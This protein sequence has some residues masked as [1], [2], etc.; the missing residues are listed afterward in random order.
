MGLVFGGAT[1][2]VDQL[3][4]AAANENLAAFTVIQFV[5]GT[6]L[7]INRRLFAKAPGGVKQLN[8]NNGAG[9]LQ[10]QVARATTGAVATS[11][12]GALVA[13]TPQFIAVTYDE[14]DGPRIFVGSLTAFFAEV[15]YAAAPT[16]GTGATSADSGGDWHFFNANANT[17]AFI[18]TGHR[19]ALYNKRMTL[20]ELQA[21]QFA[22]LAAWN[23]PN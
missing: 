21:I 15:S 1:G 17:L 18:G 16:V 22:L 20:A 19:V 6:T 4:T 14:S 9:A 13:T 5:S 8:Q 23:T 11:T 10:F 12:D 3:P 7:T 2:D